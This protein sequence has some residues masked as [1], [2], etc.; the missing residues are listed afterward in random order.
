MVDA[1]SG[2]D[3]V[4]ITRRERIQERALGEILDA[5]RDELRLHGPSGVTMRAVARAVDMTPSGLYRHVSG[6]DELLGLLAADAYEGLASV[7]AQARASAPETDHATAWYRVAMAMRQWHFAHRS[8]YELLVSPRLITV[9]P[10]RLQEAAGGAL[11]MLARIV[12]DAIESGQLDPQASAFPVTSARASEDLP[13][14]AR[15]ISLSALASLAGHVGF[16]ARGF[17]GATDMDPQEYFSAYLRGL[18]KLMGFVVEPGPL[19]MPDL[20]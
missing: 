12:A 2:P 16:E 6:H 20:H 1:G 19:V 18:M 11:E 17:L 3:R 9:V 8:E 14:A 4:G 5:A 7:M 15:S 10:D 13:A